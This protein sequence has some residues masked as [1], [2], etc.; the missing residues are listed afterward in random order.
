MDKVSLTVVINLYFFYVS[1][2]ACNITGKSLNKWQED[3]KERKNTQVLGKLKVFVFFFKL[4]RG[5]LAC[6]ISNRV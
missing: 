3:G 6:D 5:L 4:K 1:K 2:W